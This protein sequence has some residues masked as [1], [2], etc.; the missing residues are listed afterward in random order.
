MPFRS[1]KV[2]DPQEAMSDKQRVTFR[3]RRAKEVYYLHAQDLPGVGDL[4]TH[5]QE[6]W[7]VVDVGADW[8]GPLVICEP[9]NSGHSSVL[10]LVENGS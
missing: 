5:G 3:F 1:A 6:L 2:G 9:P 7:T 4:V 8:V 10:G